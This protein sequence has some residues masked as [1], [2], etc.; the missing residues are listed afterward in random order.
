MT[1]AFTLASHGRLLEAFTVQPVGALLAL[2]V[3]MA[4]IAGAWAAA[5]GAWLGPLFYAMSQ[6]RFWWIVAALTLAAWIYKLL[7][8]AA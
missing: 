4:A 7:G 1:T 6:A 8:A 2:A 3:A 5:T